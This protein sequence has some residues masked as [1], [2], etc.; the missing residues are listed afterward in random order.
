METTIDIAIRSRVE[1]LLQ[2]LCKGLYEREEAVKLALL[3]AVAG[4]SIFLLGPPGVG[5]SLIARRLK[6]A[7]R[8]GVSFEYLMSKFSTPDEIF[9]PVSIKKLKE[10]DKYERIT[11]RYLPGANVVFLDE[12][13]KAGPAIQN[14]LLTILNEKIY[15]NGS[16]D[17]KVNIRGIIT[18]SNELPPANKSLDPIWDRFLVRYELG[19]IRKFK[20]FLDMIVDTK[21]VYEDDLE[22]PLKFAEAELHEWS[23]QIDQ[24]EVPAEVLNTIQLVKVNIEAHN[25]RGNNS[26]DTIR[27]YD[28]RW[29]KMIRLMRTSAFLN[30]RKEVDLMDCF[31]M[32]HCLWSRPLQKEIIQTIVGD[33]IRKHGYSMAVNLS[34]LKREVREFEA[35]VKSEIQVKYTTTEDALL[36]VEEQYFEL[37]K[38][39]DQF[40]GKYVSIKQFQQ[41]QLDAPAVTNFY[42][43]NFNLVNRLKAQKSAKE[44]TIEIFY[45]SKMFSYALKTM[46][47]E[48]SEIIFKKPHSVV[49]KFWEDRYEKL[50]HYIEQQELKIKEHAPEQLHHLDA[51]LFVAAENSELVRANL[52]E[53]RSALQQLKLQLE[54]LRHSYINIV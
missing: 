3:S 19:N 13:W 5:K 9:G 46:Q 40:E 25:Q 27:V 6:Y 23:Q 35:D 41:L 39:D 43:P 31:L 50:W 47:V 4:E 37:I 21:D 24:V 17:L 14:A 30:G 1:Q 2:A 48:R 36:P 42:D 15:R 44:H 51:N 20:N 8:D 22:A 10:E 33:A 54:K 49:E 12:I 26:G 18:A 34:M 32:T 53:V 29:K 52:E 38:T 45:N 16:V 7:F 11:D 28:R